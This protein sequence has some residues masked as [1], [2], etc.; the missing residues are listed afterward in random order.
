MTRIIGGATFYGASENIFNKGQIY[1]EVADNRWTVNNPDPNAVYPRLAVTK[2]A[3]NQEA[4]TYWQ[5]D[6]SFLRLKNVEIGYTFPK[7]WYNKWGLSTIRLYAQGVNLLTFSKF[8]LW[9]PEL[10]SAAGSIYP[11]MK[12]GS[13][14]LNVNF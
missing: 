5:R 7:K 8:K 1:A 11:Q 4:S 13:I 12:T 3:N 9:D 6:M 10:D 14:G 2:V